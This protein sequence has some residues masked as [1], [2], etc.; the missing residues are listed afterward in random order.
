VTELICNI[1][2]ADTMIVHHANDQFSLWLSDW[3]S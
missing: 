2:E 3:V 1:L